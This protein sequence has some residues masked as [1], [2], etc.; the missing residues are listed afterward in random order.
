MSTATQLQTADDLW[1]LPND[2]MRHELVKG[3]VYTTPPAGFEHGVVGINLSTPLDQHVKPNRLG[4]VVGGETGFLIA[5]NPDTVRAPDIGFVRQARIQATGIPR[6]YWPGAPDLAV[7][8]VS[9]NDRVFEVDDKV[10]EWL[11]AGA[12]L[13]WVVNPRQR[14]VTVHRQ[15]GTVTLLTV[16]DVLDGEQV[17]PGFSIPVAHVFV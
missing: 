7:E 15:G 5:T 11:N 16:R 9:P 6:Q 8:I 2:G 14:T 12:A 13:V 1:R 10:Q 17:V 3:V 4:V